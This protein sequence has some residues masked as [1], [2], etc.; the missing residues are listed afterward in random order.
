M[1][2][3]LYIKSGKTKQERGTGVYVRENGRTV[4]LKTLDEVKKHFPNADFSHIREDIYETN[5]VWHENI[6]HNLGEM[7]R[8]VPIGCLSLYDYLWH[9]KEH[10]F[11]KVSEEYRKGIFEGLQFLKNHK[12]ELLDFEPPADPDTGKR[13]GDYNVLVSFCNSLALCLSE[14]NRSEVREIES[15]V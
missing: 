14:L 15:D 4:E 7:A 9:P 12:E 6:T 13:W 8:N 10:G 2:L 5:I 1:S 3:D 11:E